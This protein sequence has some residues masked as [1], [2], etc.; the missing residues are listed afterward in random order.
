MVFLLGVAAI[1]IAGARPLIAIFSVE[2]EVLRYGVACLRWVSYGYPFYAWG[3][4][5]E[6]AFNGAGDTYTPTMINLFTY[7][8]F[9]LPFAYLMARN[10]GF[11]PTGVF[12]AITVAESLLAVAA[13]LLFRRGRWKL[14]EV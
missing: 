6:Q 1:F 7:W 9:Q 10:A 13:L 12:V 4:V 11:G 8:V 14:R 3:M 5:M 2:A